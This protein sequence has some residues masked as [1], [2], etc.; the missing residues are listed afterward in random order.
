MF[1]NYKLVQGDKNIELDKKHFDPIFFARDTDELRK[2]EKA[3][4]VLG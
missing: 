3:K 4:K 1:G 2:N